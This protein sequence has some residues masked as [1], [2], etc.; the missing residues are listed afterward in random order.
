MF[1]ML[2]VVGIVGM[3]IVLALFVFGHKTNVAGDV[4]TSLSAQ[5]NKFGKWFKNTDPLAVFQQEVDAGTQKISKAKQFLGSAASEVRSST[6]LVHEAE[7]E[8]TRLNNRIDAVEKANDP[9]NTADGYYEQ[10]D[11]ANTRLKNAQEKL[12]RD[13][14]RFD[15]F[16]AQVVQGQ[17]D[18][19]SA[20]EKAR[21]LGLQLVQSQREKEMNEFAHSFDPHSFVGNNK[22]TEAEDAL[23][24]QIDENRGASDADSALLGQ[25]NSELKDAD[26]E[27][28]ARIQKLKEERKNK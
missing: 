10:L 20:R 4:S 15:T 5:V 24:R 7:E 8:I 27:R 12:S 1:T 22:L 9:N 23:K 19:V 11:N 21:E 26:L 17:R 28:Q 16:S 2:V 6:R 18:V 13:K 14:T 25:R 3:V